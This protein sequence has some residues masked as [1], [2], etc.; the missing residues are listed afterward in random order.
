VKKSRLEPSII[1][2]TKTKGAPELF[3]IFER[4]T[5]IQARPH[6]PA[7]AA[8]ARCFDQLVHPMRFYNNISGIRAFRKRLR[9]GIPAE[10]NN[11]YLTVVLTA[12]LSSFTYDYEHGS[13]IFFQRRFAIRVKKPNYLALSQIFENGANPSA[14]FD[15]PLHG[16]VATLFVVRCHLKSFVEA[17]FQ[18]SL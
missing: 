15:H 2:I 16:A 13:A 18:M 10:G 3:E 7:F 14:I 9:L 4:I 17:S 8:V 1:D 12:G 6:V 5:R 11:G